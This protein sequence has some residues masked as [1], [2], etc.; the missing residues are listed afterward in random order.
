MSSTAT[1]SHA[2]LHLEDLATLA[3]ENWNIPKLK[4]QILGP[5][6]DSM[7][8]NSSRVRLLLLLPSSVGGFVKRLQRCLDVAEFEVTGTINKTAPNMQSDVLQRFHELL[9][10]VLSEGEKLRGTPEWDKNVLQYHSDA[11]EW[12]AAM[13]D[14]PIGMLTFMPMFSAQLIGMWTAIESLFGDLWEAALNAHPAQLATLKGSPSRI[15]RLHATTK[16]NAT[17]NSRPSESKQVPLD[18]I[19]SHQ[20]DIRTKMGTILRQRFEFTKLASVREAYSS[21]FDHKSSRIDAALGS[22]SLDALSAMRNVLVHKAGRADD[23]YVK[24][25]AY[26]P[27][28]PKTPKSQPILLNGKIIVGLI[29]PCLEN[30]RNLMTAVDDW[31]AEN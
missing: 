15:K 2:S 26:L 7:R 31:I 17:S 10:Q 25:C 21:A 13:A 24:R 18:S 1:I 6:S 4:H 3:H 11:L 5:V 22:N 23:E 12:V 20:F 19:E 29:R 9:G 30:A 8:F 27:T 14:T 16:S 28:L